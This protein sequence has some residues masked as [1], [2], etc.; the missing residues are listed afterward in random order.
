MRQ[1]EGPVV[2]SKLFAPKSIR[3]SISRGRD[4]VAVNQNDGSEGD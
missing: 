1:S 3:P 2:S 4:R